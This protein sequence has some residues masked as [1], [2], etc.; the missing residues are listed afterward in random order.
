MQ[1]GVARELP[2]R[3]RKFHKMWG[4]Q[5]RPVNFRGRCTRMRWTAGHSVTVSEGEKREAESTKG[6]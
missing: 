6:G 3:F 2:Q 4:Q 5:S 1:T